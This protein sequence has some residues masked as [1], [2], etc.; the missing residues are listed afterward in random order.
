M[1]ALLIGKRAKILR[2]IATRLRALGWTVDTTN[3]LDID[4]LQAID[5]TQINVI[6]FGRALSREQKDT[7]IRS[8]RKQKPSIAIVEGLAPIPELLVYQILAAAY[9]ITSFSVTNTQL[10]I[11]KPLEMRVKGFRLNWLHQL[12]T[13]E[14][15]IALAQSVPTDLS[16]LMK[17][18]TYIVLEVD[19][20]FSVIANR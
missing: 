15:D 11:D 1:Q 16:A 12:K 2:T 14:T 5:V 19:G 8:F 18:F 9:P 10:H 4:Q 6:A 3:T 7:L 20:H 17:G 13:K